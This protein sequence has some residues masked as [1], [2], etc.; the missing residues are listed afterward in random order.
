MLGNNNISPYLYQSTI[1]TADGREATNANP[2]ITWERVGILDIGANITLFRKLDITLDYYDKKTTRMILY[3]QPSLES[4][5]ISGPANVGSMQNRGAEM[6]VSYGATVTKH[7]MFNISGGVSYNKTKILKLAANP[8]VS[9]DYIYREGGEMAEF[10]GYRSTGLLQQKDIAAG[11]PMLA[12]QVA[13]DIGYADRNG[14][15]RIS[16]SDRV[17]LG[18]SIPRLNYYSNLTIFFGQWDLSTLVNGVGSVGLQY[19][20][21]IANPLN[22]AGNGGTPQQFQLDY[23]TP[24][25]TNASRPRL[26]PTPGNNGLTS[27]FWIKNG[28]FARIRYLALGYTFKLK[29]TSSLKKLRVYINAQNPFTFSG[30]KVIDPESRGAEGTYPIMRVYTFGVNLSL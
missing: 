5:L 2:D 17:S 18:N 15:T 12:G 9:G 26:T 14:D 3:P 24:E 20:S 10:Y 16:D 29:P 19:T 11:V 22:T 4:A 25:H 21:R 7:L 8:L 28:A 30:V 27:S 1:N 6:A 23:W 13:G